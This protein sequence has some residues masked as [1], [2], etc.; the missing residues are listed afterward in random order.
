MAGERCSARGAQKAGRVSRCDSRSSTAAVG[1]AQR[2]QGDTSIQCQCASASRPLVRGSARRKQCR[3]SAH[4]GARWK[5]SNEGCCRPQSRSAPR[6]GNISF[7]AI[8][9]AVTR[10]SCCGYGGSDGCRNVR[11]TPRSE[12]TVVASMIIRRAVVALLTLYRYTVS[13]MLGPCC[14]FHPSCSDYSRQAIMAHGLARG[15]YLTVRR[16]L[17]CNPW[18]P[19]GHDPVP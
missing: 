18:H 19:G 14:R 8:D 9:V 6:P 1:T 13:P 2:R 17:R 5:K 12:K 4:G 7:A 16:L 10:L 15:G 11:G 3:L